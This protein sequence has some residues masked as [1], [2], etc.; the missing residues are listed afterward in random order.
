M[1]RIYN[2]QG[3]SAWK[4][5]VLKRSPAYFWELLQALTKRCC[6]LPSNFSVINLLYSSSS[7]LLQIPKRS[8]EDYYPNIYHLCIFCHYSLYSLA[9]WVLF[10]WALS[11]ASRPCRLTRQATEWFCIVITWKGSLLPGDWDEKN[12]LHKSGML[13]EWPVALPLPPKT[14]SDVQMMCRWCAEN[15]CGTR[16]ALTVH[17]IWNISLR[18]TRYFP[19]YLFLLQAIPRRHRIKNSS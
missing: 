14:C 5:F 6:T 12:D 8:V 16:S 11:T 17:A 19:Q 7:L 13:A 2:A 15:M 1:H 10:L 3:V 4:H 9:D 18:I